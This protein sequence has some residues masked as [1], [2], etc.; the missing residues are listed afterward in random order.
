[1]CVGESRSKNFD[2]P[3]LPCRI[4]SST[5]SLGG[6]RNLDSFCLKPAEQTV[7]RERQRRREIAEIE[8]YVKENIK[9]VL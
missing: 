8:R 2:L 4:P 7:W 6:M 9:A 1:M 3:F 5:P